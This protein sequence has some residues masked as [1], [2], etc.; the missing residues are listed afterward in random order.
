MTLAVTGSLLLEIPRL[1]QWWRP[2]EYMD[3]WVLGQMP[4]DFHI[5]DFGVARVTA[6]ELGG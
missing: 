6:S 3:C 4:V 5:D 1:T 2:R